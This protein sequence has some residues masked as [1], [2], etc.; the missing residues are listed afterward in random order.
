VQTDPCWCEAGTL[1]HYNSMLLPLQFATTWDCH[2]EPRCTE[3]PLELD[4]CI[5][6]LTRYHATGLQSWPLRYVS[7]PALQSRTHGNDIRKVPQHRMHEHDTLICVFFGKIRVW[8]LDTCQI[9]DPMGMRMIFYLWV[10]LISDPDRD[11]YG[12]GIFFHPWI[13]RRVPDTLLP[14]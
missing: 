10:V 2:I 7:V 5:L 14:L 3:H 4:P 8:V 1:Q 11:G 13:T 12:T 9:S 6:T